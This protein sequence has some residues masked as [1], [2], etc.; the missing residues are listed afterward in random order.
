MV[1]I[2]TLAS[3]AWLLI[4]RPTRLLSAHTRELGSIPRLV[5][6]WSIELLGDECLTRNPYS[7]RAQRIPHWFVGW[8]PSY[9]PP[10]L[11]ARDC[12]RMGPLASKGLRWPHG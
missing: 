9:D 10:V 8:V 6:R 2:M 5:I 7:P 12:A 4:S 3:L 11:A 1:T